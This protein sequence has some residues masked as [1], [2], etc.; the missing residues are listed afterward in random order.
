[1]D[2]KKATILL[3]EDEPVLCDMY[4][5]KFDVS[6]LK[7]LIAYGGYDGLATAKKEKP[8]LILLDIKMDDLDGFEVLKRLK[9]NPKMR[10]IPV[11]LLTNMGEKGNLEEGLKPG[12][13]AYIMKS[14]TVPT[15]IVSR[16]I[17]R[18]KRI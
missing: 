17:T 9:T 4:K 7:L 13:E 15:D 10:Q 14:K 8:D 6:G 1:M 18:L 2:P 3:I 12:A 11:F 16:V 5:M